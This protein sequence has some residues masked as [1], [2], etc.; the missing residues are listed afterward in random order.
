MHPDKTF[1]PSQV[2]A[3]IPIKRDT[4]QL[5]RK[6]R[7]VKVVEAKRAGR[8]VY[9]YP[10]DQV[11]KLRRMA[12]LTREGYKPLRAA[13]LAEA[14]LV[15]REATERAG[16]SK[17]EERP[18]LQGFADG[19]ELGEVLTALCLRHTTDAHEINRKLCDWLSGQG[20]PELAKAGEDLR[21]FLTKEKNQ[22]PEI[23]LV[24]VLKGRYLD[25]IQVRSLADTY[26]IH[27]TMLDGMFSR[28]EEVSAL[29]MSMDDDFVPVG[30]SRDKHYGRGS[31][32]KIPC[33]KLGRADTALGIVKL[34]PGGRSAVHSHSGDEL[35]Y[36]L[37]GEVVV[38]LMNRGLSTTI[39]QGDFFYFYAE[40]T[41]SASNF[42]AEP[43]ELF[44]IRFYQLAVEG[45]RQEIQR[46]I[47]S[48]SNSSR[49]RP[50]ISPKLEPWVRTMANIEEPGG[51]QSVDGRVGSEPMEGSEQIQARLDFGRFLQQAR[52]MRFG[53]SYSE[54]ADE[55][56]HPEEYHK[57]LEAGLEAV[58]KVQLKGLADAYGV[59]ELLL[60]NFL[61]P[62]FPSLVRVRAITGESSPLDVV[63]V[64]PQVIG[65]NRVEFY[66]PRYN[67]M[68]SDITITIAK[69]E[70]GGETPLNDYPGFD[71]VIPV[72]GTC[73][74]RFKDSGTEVVASAGE[75]QYIHYSSQ[76]SFLTCGSDEQAEVLIFRFKGSIRRP[77]KRAYSGPGK[78]LT[79]G[80][81]PKRAKAARKGL[82]SKPV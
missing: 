27:S 77:H 2:L 58:R 8:T 20:D 30:D 81:Q 7:Y 72:R 33:K 43:A 70:K 14:E 32:Y 44:I 41:H 19:N 76:G 3:E 53:G 63:R 78:D 26:G 42:S 48:W 82:D 29:A 6:Q 18:R 47:A 1:T 64:D 25:F 22:H 36:V 5:W 4:L 50:K 35:M 37:K 12:V 28:T 34:Q 79:Q 71:L 66:V 31:E 10:E 52:F 15:S 40:Q 61:Y 16:P 60:H 21:K 24:D 67:L 74:L 11:A 62:S 13:E 65:N 54:V 9:L 38:D 51:D 80:R 46:E 57:R 39:S 23:M 49:G 56:G 55:S 69:L 59:H 17:D 75:R 73:E 45:T 68:Y